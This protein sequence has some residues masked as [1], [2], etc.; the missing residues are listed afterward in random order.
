MKADELKTKSPDELKKLLLDARKKQLNL[1]FQRGG[2]QLENTAEIRKTRRLIARIKTVLTQT[3]KAA[4]T[5]DEAVTA[6]A[7]KKKAA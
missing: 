4:A 6:K 7:G 2:G 1:R 5:K 3:E